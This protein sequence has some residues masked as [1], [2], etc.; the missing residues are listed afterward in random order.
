MNPR[1]FQSP[2]DEGV[3]TR[4]LQT[5]A[6]NSQGSHV[7][8]HSKRMINVGIGTDKKTRNNDC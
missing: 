7:N 1:G 2:E 5:C 6:S 8:L 3:D 4:C